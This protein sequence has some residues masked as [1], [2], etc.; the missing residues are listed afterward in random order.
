MSAFSEFFQVIE[1]A[2]EIQLVLFGAGLFVENAS[3]FKLGSVKMDALLFG[4]E[5]TF[6]QRDKQ[7]AEPFFGLQES[8]GSTE[9]NVESEFRNQISGHGH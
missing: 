1:S 2:S 8:I 7:L 4:F 9:V 5:L 6:W 3:R